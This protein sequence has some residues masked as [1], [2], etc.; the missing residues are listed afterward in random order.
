MPHCRPCAAVTKVQ[1]EKYNPKQQCGSIFMVARTDSF[2]R[3]EAEA[4][5]LFGD[6]ASAWLRRP[7]RLLDGLT[8]YEVAQSPEG[9]WVV[10]AEL[11]RLPVPINSNL[12]S[13]GRQRQIV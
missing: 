9:A 5:R 8:P 4:S 3:V 1:S 11:R 13:R 7:S 10:L 6:G 2:S 12:V